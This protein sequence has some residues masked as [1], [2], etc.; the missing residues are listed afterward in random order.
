MGENLDLTV[1]CWGIKFQ[2]PVIIASGCWEYDEV[3]SDVFPFKHCGAVVTKTITL[4][5]REG[6]LMPRTTEVDCGM[7]N[8][9]GLQNEGIYYYVKKILPKL[10][11]EL[12]I[13][14]ITSIAGFS[15]EEYAGI[16]SHLDREENVAAIEINISCPNL[17]RSKEENLLFAQDAYMSYGVVKAVRESTTKP[18][19]VKLSPD[20]TD[21]TAVAQAVVD[22]GADGITVANTYP[23]MAVDIETRRPKLANIVGGLSG[24]AIKPLTLKKLWDVYNSVKTVPIIAS[25]G[26][27]D[28]EDALEYIICGATFVALGTVNF[29]N[30]RAPLEIVSGIKS[31]LVHHHLSYAQL[32]GSLKV[33]D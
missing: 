20:V 27:M 9:I 14:I 29:I 7:L 22:A 6:N 10:S 8:S 21:I 13:P 19:I 15:I 11:S 32:I 18:I 24:P 3:I 5:K 33:D 26:I 4:D 2:N 16:A 28:Y 25:G 17:E 23:A 12:Q 31:Y 30:P 1:E